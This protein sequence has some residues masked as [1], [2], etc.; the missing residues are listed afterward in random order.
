MGLF[1]KVFRGWLQPRA[2]SSDPH[3]SVDTESVAGAVDPTPSNKLTPVIPVHRS[4]TSP[5]VA[6][7]TSR[8]QKVYI[9]LDFGTSTTKVV[10]QVWRDT[11]RQQS[12]LILPPVD[13]SESC[14]FPST[15]A[16]DYDALVFGY[17]AESSNSQAK[18]RS[19]KM[20]LPA[21]C[22]IAGMHLQPAFVLGDSGLS[23]ED[24]S[25]LFLAWVLHEAIDRL[26]T[27]CQG[28]T[29]RVTINAAAP[30]D[31]LQADPQLKNLFHRIMFRALALCREAM[32]PWPLAIARE[33]LIQVRSLR[34][35]GEDESP[36][37]IFP[38]TH[39][40]MTAY[41]LQP[42][43]RPGL[44]ATVDIGAGTTDVAFF[45]FHASDGLPEACYYGA[46]SGFVGMDDVDHLIAQESKLDLSGVRQLHAQRHWQEINV[47]VQPD[48]EA[49]LDRIYAEYR[50]AFNRAYGRC[51]GEY[52]WVNV[53]D[54]RAKYTLCLIGG[55]ASFGPLKHALVKALPYMLMRAGEIELPTV[56]SS[57]RVVTDGNNLRPIS[58]FGAHERS[59]FLLAYGL[60]HRAIDIPLYDENHRFTRVRRVAEH[61]G[62]EEIY[63]M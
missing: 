2:Q 31:Q 3:L 18:A 35:P 25:T 17:E 58:D 20:N 30:L 33:K 8:E 34:V 22:G 39:A 63:A 19:F 42:G 54:R 4:V 14:L 13:A 26:R 5:P 62:H 49:V 52:D 32:N 21:E 36:V 51:P 57:L 53:N 1:D 7:D 28:A 44:Y 27:V 9:G 37:M 61:P 23:A 47:N 16:L 46:N 48:V 6:P 11:A 59:L 60:A 50:R 12:F 24:A 45:W 56:P 55:G 40:A 43:R 38:E 29:L 15:I 10:A 41:I